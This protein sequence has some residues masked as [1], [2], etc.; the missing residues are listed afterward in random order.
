MADSAISTYTRHAKYWE[1]E[2]RTFVYAVEG[3]TYRF[4]LA[5]LKMMSPPLTAI[6]D[7]PFSGVMN[8]DGHVEGSE[9]N[10]IILSGITSAQLNDF[11]S[12][13]FKSALVPV[14]ELPR[15][16]QE[17]FCVN[18]L[19][20]G[21]IWDIGE[22]TAYAKSVLVGLDLSSVRI[23]Q[24]AKRFAIH[25][26]VEA[27]VRK[28]VPIVGTLGSD[29]ALALGPITLNILNQ[30]KCAID[31]ERLYVAHVAPKLTSADELNYGDCSQ[32]NHGSCERSVKEL[33]WNLVGR[34]VLHPTNPMALDA[35]GEFLHRTT[36]HGMS[37]KCQDNMVI[38]WTT[39]FFE[40]Q[41]IMD[42][43]VKAVKEFHVYCRPS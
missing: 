30:A 27:A 40:E 7:I 21:C 17:Q 1:T 32:A 12:Y 8:K 23:L 33:W 39:N 38:K 19:T 20:V 11:L 31:T 41:S 14:E 5:L 24:I 18:L 28:L 4:P 42:E 3:T 9:E 29:D 34:K 22:A 36:F 43:A 37:Q 16:R 35:I 10:P 2:S 6:F 13:F 15:A 26:W 25:D